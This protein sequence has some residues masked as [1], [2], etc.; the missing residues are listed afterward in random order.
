MGVKQYPAEIKAKAVAMLLAGSS[1][2]AVSKQLDMPFSTVASWYYEIKGPRPS[3]LADVKSQ[4]NGL[5]IELDTE[6]L[7]T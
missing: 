5:L 4:I 6:S 3:Y 7:I 2:T 1:V